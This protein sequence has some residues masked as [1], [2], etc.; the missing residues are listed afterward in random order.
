MKDFSSSGVNRYRL[1]QGP[2]ASGDSAGNYGAFAIELRRNTWAIVVAADGDE[3]GWEHVSAHVRYVNG[4]GKQV[5]RTPTWEEMCQVK[6]WFWE[7]EEAVVQFH[8]P[9]SE[10][11]N[12]HA[13]CLHL[14]RPE[15]GVFPMPP[16]I[17]VGPVNSAKEGQ[18]A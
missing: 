2:L 17:L 13:H 18:G 11:V 15:D 3:S 8:P 1:R 10:Y 12:L 14:W 9:Q 16:S 5:L 4:K 7:P 6:D